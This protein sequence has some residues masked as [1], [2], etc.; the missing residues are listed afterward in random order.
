[1]SRSRKFDAVSIYVRVEIFCKLDFGQVHFPSK[2]N[3]FLQ[4]INTDCLGSLGKF[5]LPRYACWLELRLSRPFFTKAFRGVQ[6]VDYPAVPRT[7]SIVPESVSFEQLH[8]FMDAFLP[9][10]LDSSL[11]CDVCLG[12]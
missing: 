4:D 2:S 9:L 5:S 8:Y 12:C 3:D 6:G 11:D 1:M 7:S 10:W